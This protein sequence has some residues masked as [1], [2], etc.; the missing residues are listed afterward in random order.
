MTPAGTLTTLRAFTGT[1]GANPFAAVIQMPDGALYG[2]TSSGGG[3]AGAGVIYRLRLTSAAGDFDWDTKADLTVF[4]PSTGAWWTLHPA[5]A[6]MIPPASRGTNR[7]GWCRP[8]TMAMADGTSRWA[9][10][11]RHVV[12]RAVEAD[13]MRHGASVNYIWETQRQAGGRRSMATADRPGIWRPSTVW[14]P[15]VSTNYNT[16]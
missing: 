4:R 2:T 3:S 16:C 9:S 7:T 5:A 15:A 12:H 6:S 8:I 14:Y 1:D 11:G 10:L 13:P